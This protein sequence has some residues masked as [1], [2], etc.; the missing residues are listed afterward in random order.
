M[1]IHTKFYIFVLSK[2]YNATNL[3]SFS[4]LIGQLLFINWKEGGRMWGLQVKKNR[5]AAL[6]M[7][8]TV[9]WLPVLLS[10]WSLG[11][12]RPIRRE[13]IIWETNRCFN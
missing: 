7:P 1:V 11:K 2:T 9:L 5:V 13:R 12:P 10:Y 4:A 8:Q 3:L 6:M